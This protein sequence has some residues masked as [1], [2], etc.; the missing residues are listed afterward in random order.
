M[1]EEITDIDDWF[2]EELRRG[3]TEPR[4]PAAADH[5]IRINPSW[6]SGRRLPSTG[7][8]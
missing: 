8:R 2:E 4:V 5:Y 6:I 1:A 7:S 3:A